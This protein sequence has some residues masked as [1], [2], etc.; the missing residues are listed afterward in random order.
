VSVRVGIGLP[1]VIPGTDGRTIVEW[2]RAAEDAGFA[3]LAVIDRLLYDGF[4]PVIALAAAA[5]ATERIGLMTSTLVAPSRTN[6][7]LL[8]KQLASVSVIGDGRLTVGL[9]IG[10]RVEDYEAGGVPTAG[11]G[12]RLEAQVAELRRMWSDGDIG[13]TLARVPPILLGGYADAV[14]RRVAAHADGW[15]GGGAGV[16]RFAMTAPAVRAAWAEAGRDG[17]PVFAGI[18]YFA[19]GPDARATADAYLLRYY[20]Y[21]GDG[22]GRIAAGASTDPATVAATVAAYAAAGCDE[23]LLFPCTA[24]LAEVARLAGVLESVPE[25]ELIR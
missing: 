11:R 15:I 4:E 20:A 2:A 22:A 7:A 9:S 8:A 10:S 12:Q 17:E 25:A 16:E 23:L 19:L 21:A 13:P 3:T 1:T 6:T 24:D 5:A 14:P 18:G